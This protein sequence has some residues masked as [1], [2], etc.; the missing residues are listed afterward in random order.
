M[1]KHA[2]LRELFTAIANSIRG[3]TG[4]TDPIVA[5]DFPEAIDGITTGGGVD[6]IQRYIELKGNSFGKLF[7]QFYGSSVDEL[8]EGVDTSAITNMENAFY[9][10]NKLTSIPLFDTKN[11]TIM[12][13]MLSN[14]TM[15]TSVPLFDTRNVT[16][17]G[18]MFE[19]C[20]MLTSVPLFDTRNVTYLYA[21]FSR[22]SSL[23]TVP[24]FDV[25]NVTT[26]SSMLNYCNK[27]EECWLRNIKAN[28]QV[29]SGTSYGHLLTL[30]SLLSLCKECCDTGSQKTLTIGS[31]NLEKLANVY[32]KLITITDDMRVEDDLID[33][34][35]PFVQCESTD[36]DAMTLAD[37][38]ALKK[39]TLA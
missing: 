39:W 8:L 23:T 10:C 18:T 1:A 29:G 31:A 30:E 4:G 35:Y 12:D 26:L 2:N 22:C 7:Y 15:L 13:S 19:R 38:M 32:V 37:Y 21:M 25:R 11:V 6:K 3:K 27:L 14:C 5:D 24:A 16:R 34:K 36:A 9:G 28:L 17:M 20:S 33:Q